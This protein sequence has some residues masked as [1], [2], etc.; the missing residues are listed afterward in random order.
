MGLGDL[1]AEHVLSSGAAVVRALRTG[2][3][4]DGPAER[5]LLVQ[6]EERV[7]LLHAEPDL[8]FLVGG[9]D[10][11]GVRAGVGGERGAAGR[12]GV[13]EH[14]DVVLVRPEGITEDGPRLDDDLRVLAGGLS[15]GAA[16]EVPVWQE[17]NL[18]LTRREGAGLGAGVA[19]GVN[20]DVLRTKLARVKFETIERLLADR[21]EGGLASHRLQNGL[22]RH[23]KSIR[24]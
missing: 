24:E 19:Y 2:E 22:P 20:P 16:V 3:A 10:L 13:A 6:V 5:G 18:V 21:V 4:A 11:G 14:Q 17:A 23:D 8:L 7:L 9:E 1:P 12:V 15:S